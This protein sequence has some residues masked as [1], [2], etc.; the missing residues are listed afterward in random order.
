MNNN[1]NYSFF[2]R[3]LMNRLAHFSSRHNLFLLA[4]LSPLVSLL[5]VPLALSLQ[6][7]LFAFL[8]LLF[9]PLSLF[10]VVFLAVAEVFFYNS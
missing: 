7:E 3:S 5:F 4:L 9:F 10:T 2:H 8:F 1:S 6:S